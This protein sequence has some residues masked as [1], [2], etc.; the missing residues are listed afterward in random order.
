MTMNRRR[1]IGVGAGGLAGLALGRAA[2]AQAVPSATQPATPPV[3]TPA[4]A[5][6]AAPPKTAAQWIEEFTGGAPIADGGVELTAPEIAENGNTVPLAVSAPGAT[7]I[8]LLAPENP[9]AGVML[10]RFGPAAGSRR[11][12]TRI[13]MAKTQEL[14]ALARLED[15]SI[16]RATATVKV[17]VGG[18]GG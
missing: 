13:R 15:G 6:A 16:H 11:L 3:M 1:L 4:P 8:L 9:F 2:F 14:I 17:T 5:T 12:A 10:A 7:Q 18:C